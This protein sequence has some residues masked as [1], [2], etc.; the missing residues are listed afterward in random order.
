MDELKEKS[1]YLSI[2]FSF[3]EIDSN[4][5]SIDK[6][7]E[8]IQKEKPGLITG[9]Y[10]H[11]SIGYWDIHGEKKTNVTIIFAKEKKC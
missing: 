10:D 7:L 5:E 9:D 2:D 6:L 3:N 1:L 4:I 11:V 8:N